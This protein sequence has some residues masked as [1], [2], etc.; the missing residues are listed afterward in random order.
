MKA[1]F[2]RSKGETEI[3]EFMTSSGHLKT[4]KVYGWLQ[5]K[6]KGTECEL[7]LY[8][9]N[10]ILEDY[11]DYLFLPFKDLTNGVTSYG[12]GRY[13]ELT[14]EDFETEKVR[15]DFNKAF[16]PYCAYSKYY[17]CP[18]PPENNHLQV[19]IPVGAAYESQ[20]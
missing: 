10:P 20:Y 12:G 17:S 5:F 9:P 18:I 14:L 8:Q 15:I 6:I 11:P 19:E 16:N 13:I 4:Y 3:V 7:T 1:D 2:Q